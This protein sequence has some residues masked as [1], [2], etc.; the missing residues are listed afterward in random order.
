LNASLDHTLGWR[1]SSIVTS[2][3]NW[4]SASE[5]VGRSAVD[6]QTCD[7]ALQFD[8]FNSARNGP[9]DLG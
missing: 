3:A 8:R 4:K 6:A 5:A 2:L 9:R 1:C 7:E